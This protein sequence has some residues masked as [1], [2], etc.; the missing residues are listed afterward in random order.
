MCLVLQSFATLV[1][2][3]RYCGQSDQ[4][5]QEAMWMKKVRVC[6]FCGSRMGRRDD[7]RIAADSLEREIAKRKWEIVYGAGDIGLMGRIA[8]S[9]IQEGGVVRGFIPHA[10]TRTE[11]PHQKLTELI[12]AK[13]IHERKMM[14]GQSADV[15][16]VLPGGLGTL[17]EFA[18]VISLADL[19]LQ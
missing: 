9:A 8:N 4:L 17:E 18:E 13:T 10:L 12:I 6:V 16:V 2:K 19:G 15:F 3:Y 5:S 11:V 14:M 1:S 7:Y